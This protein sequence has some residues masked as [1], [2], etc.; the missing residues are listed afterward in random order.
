MLSF[1]ELSIAGD[2]M[3]ESRG[4]NMGSMRINGLNLSSLNSHSNSR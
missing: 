4:A 2:D 3:D 1:N